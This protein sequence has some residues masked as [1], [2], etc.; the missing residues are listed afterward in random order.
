MQIDRNYDSTPHFAYSCTFLESRFTGK[1]RDAESG[2]DYFGARYYASNMGRFM[3]PDPS[4]L[5]F[6]DPTNPQSLNLYSYAWNNP[7]RNID[8]NGM[9]CVWDDGSYDAADDADTGNADKCSGQGGTWVDPNLFENAQLTNGQNANIQY[10]QWSG[11]ASS[12]ITSNW[13][14]ASSTT[15]GPTGAELDAVDNYVNDVNNNLG[16]QSGFTAVNVWTWAAKPRTLNGPGNWKALPASL[17]FHGNYCGAGG[18][19]D[20]VDGL[21]ASCMVHDFFYDQYG[22]SMGS[23]FQNPFSD[24]DPDPTLQKINQ[25]LC[26]GASAA[27]GFSGGA[28]QGYFTYGV[29]PITGGSGVG[30]H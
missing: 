7:L 18:T 9:E 3:S 23:N 8:P 24:L 15:I 16:L 2:L 10:G 28:V 30:C 29:T 25:G 20:P 4:S 26:D 21:D 11:Q 5:A 12:A 6:A 1:E 17:Y 22:Y 27:G 19:G 13:L 14:G